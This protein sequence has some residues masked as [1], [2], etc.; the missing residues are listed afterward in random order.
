MATARK[1]AKVAELQ[2]KLGQ[3]RAAILTDYRGLTVGQ[4]QELRQTLSANGVEYRV[5]KNTLA[6]R[7]ASLA[8][9]PALAQLFSGPV[10]VAVSYDDPVAPARLLVEHF[11]VQRRPLILSGWVEGRTVN[12]LEVR[13]LAELPSREVLL[14]QLASALQAPLARLAGSLSAPMSQL[15]QGLKQLVELRQQQA[16]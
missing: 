11:R 3:A 5:V 4:I 1:Q 10:A 12:E 14:A 6:S 7:A 15:A 8:G 13:A 16:G 9:R 2:A